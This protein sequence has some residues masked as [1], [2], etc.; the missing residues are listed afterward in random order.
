MPSELRRIIPFEVKEF[1]VKLARTT[2]DRAE[3]KPGAEKPA[4]K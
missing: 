3:K 1:R 4:E 2:L